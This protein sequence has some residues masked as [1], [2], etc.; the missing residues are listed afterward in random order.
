M[1]NTRN[2]F[3][4]VE[5]STFEEDRKASNSQETIKEWEKSIASIILTDVKTEVTSTAFYTTCIQTRDRQMCK[6]TIDKEANN[7]GREGERIFQHKRKQ[8]EYRGGTK[9]TLE[10]EDCCL[11]RLYSLTI[12]DRRCRYLQFEVFERNSLAAAKAVPF[13]IPLC[14]H[15]RCRY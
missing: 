14:R 9:I 12:V 8:A 2:G 4:D 15:S 13:V 6:Q 3:F 7:I 11:A 10:I 1:K 5:R